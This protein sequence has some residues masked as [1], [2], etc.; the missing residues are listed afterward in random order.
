MAGNTSGDKCIG[1]LYLDIS[2]V[3]TNIDDVN[4]FL[5]SIGANINLEEKLSKKVSAAL[6]NLVNEAKKAGEEAAKAVKEP[7]SNPSD[8]QGLDSTMSKI[9][10]TVQTIV[11]TTEDAMGKVAST[12]T[13]GFDAAGNKIKEFANANGEI[14]KRTEEIRNS[15]EEEMELAWKAYEAEEKA[16][17]KKAEAAVQAGLK[18]EE[19]A[20]RASQAE[21]DR[22]DKDV[23]TMEE[24]LAKRTAAEE[25]ALEKE[26]QA[27]AAAQEKKRQQSIDAEFAREEARKR[28]QAA[29]EAQMA[30]ELQ[31]YDEQIQQQN[32]KLDQQITKYEEAEQR[33]TQ[34]SID[35]AFAREEAA[36]R[37][38]QAEED[39]WRK[40]VAAMEESL[41]NKK[42]EE[43]ETAYKNLTIA[44][45]NYNIEK[46]AGNDDRANIWQREIEAQLGVLSNLEQEIKDLDI[47]EQKRRQILLLI[48]QGRTAQSGMT[49]ETQNTV[50][51]HS[52]WERQLTSLATRY[53]SLIAIIRMITSLV[54]DTVKYVSE[55]YDKMNEIRIIT[56]KTETEVEQLGKTY[57]E[58]AK[59]M[60]VSS[61]DMADAAIYFTRQG[62][63]A[64][65]VE[66]R[67]KYTTQYAKTA[68]IEFERSAELITAVVNSMDLENDELADGRDA[69]QRVA[70]VFLKIG[71][72][73]ATS[74]EEI[75]TAMQKA[76]AAAGA[77]GVEFE[78]LAASIATVS[79][80]TRQEAS[81]IGTAFNTLIARLHNIRTAGYN[82]EDE[83]KINDIQKAL[84]N[85]NIALLDQDGN[86]R[87]ME[88]IFQEI[89]EKWDT[90][91]DKTKSYIATTMAGVKQQ[92]VFLALMEDM[93]KATEGAS[94]Q[95][96]LYGLALESAG[97]A[98]E[99]YGTYM[100]SVTAAQ[101]RLTVAQEEFYS[102]L[103]ADVVKTYYNGLAGIISMISNGIKNIQYAFG[104]A[105]KAFDESSALLKKHQSLVD[106]DVSTQTRL[107]EMF[108]ELSTS[109]ESQNVVLDKY[110]TL[111]GT[112]G[113]I[114]PHAAEVVEK[115]RQG[116]IDQ[117]TAAKEL[118]EELER[119]INNNAALAQGD[120][121]TKIQNWKPTIES[122][123]QNGLW[124]K[125]NYSW[126][127]NDVAS[128]NSAE[129]FTEMLKKYYELQ[130]KNDPWDVS[131][132][133]KYF[134]NDTWN[135]IKSMLEN[136]T[137]KLG[138]TEEE[139]WGIIGSYL[140]R[141]LFGEMD[142]NGVSDAIKKEVS[143]L[144]DEAVTA[145]GVGLDSN[146]KSALKQK[147]MDAIIGED[148]I[149]DLEEYKNVSTSLQQALGDFI[150]NGIDDSYIAQTIANRLFGADAIDDLFQYMGDDFSKRF[151]EQYSDAIAN[152]FSDMDISKIFKESGAPIME[153]DNIGKILANQ[154]K[155]SIAQAFGME[156]LSMIFEEIGDNGE[157]IDTYNDVAEGWNNIDIS[158]LKTIKTM[159][160]AGASFAEINAI[161]IECGSDT[162]LIKQKL[163]ELA[164][165]IGV[166]IDEQEESVKSWADYMKEIKTVTGEIENLNK[167]IEKVKNGE[168]FNG[169]EWNNLIASHPELMTMAGDI[170]ALTQKVEEFRAKR[171]QLAQ[172]A[173][174]GNEQ[175]FSISQFAGATKED[176][177]GF[178]TLAEYK[179][180]L[181][182]AGLSTEELDKYVEQLAKGFEEMS[183]K[184]DGG[185]KTLKELQ[186]E[187]DNARKELDKLD[188]AISNLEAGKSLKFDDLLDLTTAHPE[189]MEVI[190]DTEKLKEALK[191]IREQSLE[192]FG[193]KLE[194]QL[195][196][197]ADIAKKLVAQNGWEGYVEG[198]TLEE[199]KATL[200]AGDATAD[201]IVAFISATVDVLKQARQELDAATEDWLDA[202]SEQIQKQQELNYA[203]STGFE[204]QI[205][206]LQ[207]ALGDGGEAGVARALEIWEMYDSTLKE[208]IKSTY[209]NL[210]MAMSNASKA[211][212]ETENRT[213]S[214]EKASK[215]LQNV[216]GRS[217]KY[218]TAKYFKDTYSAIQK[219][220][221]GTISATDA[222]DA[223]NKEV[224]KV[225]KAYEDILDVQ[226]K[227]EHNAKKVNEN[228]QKK[229]EASDVSNLATLLNMTTD[230]ILADFPSAV[231]MFDEL[232]GSTGELTQALNLL[233]QAAFVK[234]TGVSEADFSNLEN[235][236]FAVRAGAE[237]TIKM[238]QATGQWEITS[239][240]LPQ[241]AKVYDPTSKTWSTLKEV[242]KATVLKPTGNNPF[243]KQSSIAS[244]KDASTKKGSGGG[245]GSSKD[246]NNNFRDTNVN[247]E[248]ERMLDMMSQVNTIQQSQQNYYQS[249]QKYYSQTGQ[250]QGVIAYMQKESEVLAAQNPILEENIRKIEDYMAQKRAE[251]ATL[252]TDDEKY[253]EVADDL[254]KLQ[255]AHQTYTK[256]LIDNKTAMDQLSES[257]KE[258]QKKIRQMEIDL[259]NT[260]LKAIQDRET[261]KTNML[262]AEIQMENTI[263]ELIKKRYEVER[264][265]IIETSNL[266]INALKDE[267]DLL[268]EQLRI[269]KEQAE[270]EEKE[271]K[272]RELEAKYQRILADPTRRKEAQ[273]IKAE[274]DDLRKEM[275][276]D[277]AENEVKA[278]QEAIDQQI[279]SLED[280]VE[281]VE[282]YYEDLFEH[283]QKLIAEMRDIMALTQSEIIE[284]LKANDETYKNS[285]ENTQLQMVNGWTETYNEMKGILIEYWDEVEEIIAQGDD[286]II[287]FLKNNASEY[288][289][290]G[291]LQAEAYVDEWKK[292]LDDLHKAYQTVTAEVA[293][294]YDTIKQYTGS[295]S[296]SSSS[297]SGGGG[298]GS[299]NGNNKETHGY[300]FTWKGSTNSYTKSKS[301]EDAQEGA[302]RTIESLYQKELE[303]AKK[304][305]AS[306]SIAYG[307]AKT[308]AT[309]FKA[310]ALSSIKAYKEGGMADETGPV[311]VDGTKQLPERILS[312]HQTELFET[313]VEALDRMSRINVESMPNFG[314]MQTTGGGN[315]SVGDIIVNVDNL[316]T[317]DDYEELADKV[318][319]VL[320]DR[321]GRSAV[322]GGLRIRST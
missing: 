202:Q 49:T 50:Q 38:A 134:D 60:N 10:T 92:N 312:P 322:V 148:G 204:S 101:E 103:G 99:K 54:K 133:K 224:N 20:A 295:S 262:N 55:Y 275:A 277:L 113:E 209:P 279:T 21:Q 80:T 129:S 165:Q 212:K 191:G 290:A 317:D 260:I 240:D 270:A 143:A 16:E 178:T 30:K 109:E 65:D 200:E 158:T 97:T 119:V 170:E 197:D 175:I 63:A 98:E 199:Y 163:A 105:N 194:T 189:I 39:L 68:N 31:M 272:L 96:E 56:G 307:V 146:G 172:E 201:A 241:T 282:N 107:K 268:D 135:E 78:W 320:M 138:K 274:I 67:L 22:A 70:D 296:G 264:D 173:I 234:I 310:A 180:Y 306:N 124:N 233:N 269:R 15:I 253:K 210:V 288:A 248:V 130:W 242:G 23:A 235:G 58:L 297:G 280:Y 85:I 122:G 6:K 52:G 250:L 291:K 176:G 218:A 228:N 144:V 198:Q 59:D 261:K 88:T 309:V 45:R 32:E 154:L 186:T 61:L 71:D 137:K 190:G 86:W 278:Q 33:K 273:S 35:A 132:N 226:A 185:T 27:D 216:L 314:N 37:A 301:L 294:N 293:A 184:G 281:Y 81:S 13:T 3:K 215:E 231:A 219:L 162:D 300:T 140:W 192:D 64:A 128:L 87:K 69:A 188:T 40:E 26:I 247:T 62:L 174:M 166:N 225:S 168:D 252:S 46:R 246:K 25:A 156:D 238:L 90:L 179:A 19:A 258:Q 321:L 93:S 94:R 8:L 66:E 205:N 29:E 299:G 217:E 227:Q 305:Y 318:S 95:A 181:E 232:T 187:T 57:R 237:E 149:L 112:I 284:W 28:S 171:K 213:K 243:S 91:N 255:K 110:N 111:L 12:V 79:E 239:V 147:F 203:K 161:M 115:L 36:Q 73:A 150:L 43:A 298:G 82:A 106:E 151:V 126:D 236:L 182:E 196:N 41:Q 24:A 9:S 160:D 74:G 141:Q 131:G 14:T 123:N 108:D 211:T 313:M 276:W 145:F 5:G 285:S 266:R 1:R 208:S 177:T 193:K 283:P 116:F 11:R 308:Q 206:Q 75:G 319:A 263:F 304:K 223:F 249:Q 303:D 256:Q 157:I 44:I 84:A 2:Q 18:R 89:A 207:A 155:Q 104:I 316:D 265:E 221:E 117:K 244:L 152:G 267:R 289:E 315:V 195:M 17:Q 102:L 229:I 76:A 230:E 142:T 53:F 169:T 48:E 121:M 51:A 42:V 167:V 245:G 118:N 222:Y 47:D 159:A 311:W 120:F 254:D 77:F 100:E 214:L 287:E 4:K 164:E 83:T 7:L 259:R 271:V 139:A 72:N 251:I 220:E 125:M 292:Q 183:E 257:I 302:K 136:Q 286:Y 34:A 153:L 127:K 114:S